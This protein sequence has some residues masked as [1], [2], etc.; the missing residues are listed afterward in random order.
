MKM[1][2]AQGKKSGIVESEDHDEIYNT[3]YRHVDTKHLLWLISFFLTL[4]NGYRSS[5]S[6]SI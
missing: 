6:I 5:D 3:Y 4:G 1:E 2:S